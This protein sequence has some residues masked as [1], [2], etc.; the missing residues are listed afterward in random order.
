VFRIIVNVTGRREKPMFSTRAF[1]PLKIDKL[2]CEELRERL[3]DFEIL[4]RRKKP[5]R[6]ERV[7]AATVNAERD[8]TSRS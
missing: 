1:N 5:E 2:A 7:V 6:S 8:S 3:L 4:V